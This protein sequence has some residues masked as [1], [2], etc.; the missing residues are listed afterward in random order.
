MMQ[1]R[2]VPRDVLGKQN[3][4]PYSRAC[5]S[6]CAGGVEFFVGCCLTCG[7]APQ[8]QPSSPGHTDVGVVPRMEYHHKELFAKRKAVIPNEHLMLKYKSTV[9]GHQLYSV[10]RVD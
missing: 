9:G 3:S 8:S 7:C 6:T 10:R 1:G 5:S 2:H 4:Q